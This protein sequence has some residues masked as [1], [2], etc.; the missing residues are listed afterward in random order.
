[1]KALPRSI[2]RGSSYKHTSRK[3]EKLAMS[4]HEVEGAH[5]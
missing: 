1:M 3:E 4:H 5:P 2:T